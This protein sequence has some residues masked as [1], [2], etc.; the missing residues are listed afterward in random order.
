[1]AAA[2]VTDL[3]HA[4]DQVGGQ[5]LYLWQGDAAS[6]IWAE[7]ALT[8]CRQ[9]TQGPAP[10]KPPEPTSTTTTAPATE[11]PVTTRRKRQRVDERPSHK[12]RAS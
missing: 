9:E 1:M 7:V 10:P 6:L 5:V 3:L 4:K 11:A 2:N 8:A 12:D